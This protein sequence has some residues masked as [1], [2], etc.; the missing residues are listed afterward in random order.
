MVSKTSKL[1]HHVA[2]LSNTFKLSLLV[3]KLMHVLLQDTT[4]I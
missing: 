2:T 4:F 3:S 1:Q